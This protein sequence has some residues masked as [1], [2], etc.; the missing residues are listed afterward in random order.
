M[1]SNLVEETPSNGRRFPS[2]EPKILYN[3]G[4]S[5]ASAHQTKNTTTY[6]YRCIWDQILGRHL[7]SFALTYKR[8]EKRL[9]KK[10]ERGHIFHLFSCRRFQITSVKYAVAYQSMIGGYKTYLLWRDSDMIQYTCCD[11]TQTWIK[12]L[13]GISNGFTE[14]ITNRVLYP[15]TILW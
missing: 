4:M 1:A 8:L 13:R 5:L 6:V 9:A 14:F 7:P 12:Y 11:V 3:V 2:R 10:K 15:P